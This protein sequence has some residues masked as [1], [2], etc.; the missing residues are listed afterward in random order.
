MAFRNLNTIR[1]LNRVA[2]IRRESSYL[3]GSSKSY[4]SCISNAI[5][6]NCQ[7]VSPYLY[8]GHN[9][10]LWTRGSNTTLCSAMAAELLIFSNGTRLVTTQAKAPP[11]ARQM[12]ALKVSMSSPGFVYEPYAPRKPIPFWQRCAQRQIP[13][14]VFNLVQD[15]FDMSI[16]MVIQP[17]KSAYAINKLRKSGYSK[18][19]FYNEAVQLYKEINTLLANGDKNSLRKAVTE[20]MYSALKNEIK[21]RESIWDKVYWE[22]IEPV[23]KI[24]TLRAR[25]ASIGVDRNDTSKVFVQITLEFLAKQKFEAYDSNGSVVAG[26]KSKE[27]LVRDIWV[28]E[29]SLFHPGSYWRLCGRISL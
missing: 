26:D 8:N 4:S 11:Q 14:L 18:R 28:F 21:Q 15:M 1:S 2:Q 29:K 9:A 13:L 10:L 22:L 12:G 16:R 24:R 6:L 25:L 5:E 19:L 20:N 17:L 7:K 23:L 27:V 3:L